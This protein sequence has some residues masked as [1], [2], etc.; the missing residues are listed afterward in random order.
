M[1]RLVNDSNFSPNVGSYSAWKFEKR[2]N[3]TF[4][5]MTWKVRLDFESGFQIQVRLSLCH[6][7]VASSIKKDKSGAMKKTS[8]LADM[9]ILLLEGERSSKK[10]RLPKA[11]EGAGEGAVLEASL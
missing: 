9:Q 10:K 3:S 11:G 7:S 8:C 4:Q 6:M 2:W 5:V 1:A